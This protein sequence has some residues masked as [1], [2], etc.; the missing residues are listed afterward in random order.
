[1]VVL[2]EIFHLIHEVPDIIE[3]WQL[4]RRLALDHK[5]LTLD[6]LTD[7]INNDLVDRILRSAGHI[8]C[9]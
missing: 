5:L 2:S 4:N 9:L 1:M 7:A 3:S 8:Y 6:L